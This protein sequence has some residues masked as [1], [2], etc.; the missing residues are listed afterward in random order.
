MAEYKRRIGLTAIIAVVAALGIGLVAISA[1]PSG[2][3]TSHTTANGPVGT[4]AVLLGYDSTADVT[5]TL[6]TGSC[7]MTIV[8]NSTVPLI[9][10]GCSIA[11]VVSTNGTVTTWNTFNGTAGGPAAAGIPAAGSNSHGSQVPG[12]CTVSKSDLT[13]APKGS[14]VSGGFLVELANS[15]YNYPVGTQARISFEGTWS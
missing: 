5:C 10:E 14:F 7:T 11:P 9:V 3:T 13:G 4:P 8:N 12:S 2:Q 15:W 1:F 6:A